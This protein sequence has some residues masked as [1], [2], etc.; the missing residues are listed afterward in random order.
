[1]TINCIPPAEATP[2]EKGEWADNWH[3]HSSREAAAKKLCRGCDRI[4]ACL[5]DALTQPN[6]HTGS[7]PTGIFGGTTTSERARIRTRRNKTGNAD[8]A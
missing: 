3:P 6:P 7:W 2:A 1:M 4:T 8:A 5:E